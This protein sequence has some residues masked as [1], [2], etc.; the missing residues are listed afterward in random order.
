LGH[1]SLLFLGSWFAGIPPALPVADITQHV[2]FWLETET[3][4]LAAIV[5]TETV[6]AVPAIDPFPL[7]I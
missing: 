4:V 6:F 1:Y 3:G 2:V 5:M 7:F